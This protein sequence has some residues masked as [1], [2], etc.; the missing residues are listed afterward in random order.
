VEA[1]IE[2]PLDEGHGLRQLLVL[3]AGEAVG[4]TRH[5]QEP[6]AVAL[7][8]VLLV[9][10][11]GARGD[12]GAVGSLVNDQ[13][14]DRAAPNLVDL[15]LSFGLGGRGAVAQ[16]CRSGGGD[17]GERA[18]QRQRGPPAD[19]LMESPTCLVEHRLTGIGQHPVEEPP[20]VRAQ[21][22]ALLAVLPCGERG[23]RVEVGANVGPASLN[24]VLGQAP[25]VAEVGLSG[26]VLGQLGK[27]R[28]QEG[29]Q[30]A[31]GMLLT[32]VGR[33]G[34]KDHVPVGVLGQAADQ[35]VALVAPASFGTEGAGMGL[36]DDHE[37][38]TGAAEFLAASVGLDVIERDNDI[39]VALEERL[40]DG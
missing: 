32:A 19:A 31:E 16:R 3:R 13:V 6:A 4:A 25:P 5:L 18:Q 8:L 1:V 39:G 34:D 33:G 30:R 22:V 2:Q 38:G 10:R 26:Q 17:R 14:E 15:L 21:L 36:I 28:I 35:L 29:E 24:E 7:A 37:L 40:A 12:V 9:A 11:V 27:V 20:V 23:V